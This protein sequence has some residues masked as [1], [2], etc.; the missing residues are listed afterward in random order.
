MIM[1][2]FRKKVTI[3][4]IKRSWRITRNCLA[5]ICESAKSNYP[6]EFAGLL[7]VSDDEKDT[8]TEIMLLPGTISGDSHAIFQMHMRP[9]DFSLVGTIHSHPTGLPQ[10]SEADL[11]LFSKY[12]KVHMIVAH[13]FTETS[14]KAYDAN[15]DEAMMQI[16]S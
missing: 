8:I 13:P 4:P 1:S 2:F 5:L 14:W 10:P 16:I 15:G 3:P 9:I 12:G 7:R 11:Q 6:R